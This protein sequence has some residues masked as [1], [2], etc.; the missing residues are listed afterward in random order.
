VWVLL[1]TISC[2]LGSTND[3]L[4]LVSLTF[5]LL[6]FAGLEFCIGFLMAVLLR[7]F[8][9]LTESD[10]IVSL[11]NFTKKQITSANNSPVSAV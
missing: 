10:T 2:Y 3:D 8:K 7:N 5:F 1:Y 4:N 11:I 6:A 9:K